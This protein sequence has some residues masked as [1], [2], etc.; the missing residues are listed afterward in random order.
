M[1][2]NADMIAELGEAKESTKTRRLKDTVAEARHE[3]TKKMSR[4]VM[5]C[6]DETVLAQL[7]YTRQRMREEFIGMSDEAL[8]WLL[9]G[10]SEMA[11][12]GFHENDAQTDVAKFR[13]FLNAPSGI[14]ESQRLIAGIESIATAMGYRA[15]YAK[16]AEPPF[17]PETPEQIAMDEKIREIMGNKL[18]RSIGEVYTARAKDDLTHQ[19]PT[20]IKGRVIVVEPEDVSSASETDEVDQ[21]PQATL[22][23]RIFREEVKDGY[24]SW[25]GAA[26]AGGINVRG[27]TSGTAPL[28]LAAVDGLCARG[29]APLNTW[30]D[31]QAQFE[32][33]A[34]ALAIAPYER[35]DYHSIAETAA[36]IRHY[37]LERVQRNNPD[38]TPMQPYDAFKYGV[39]MLINA[40][41]HSIQKNY[42]Q[43]LREALKEYADEIVSGV[44]YRPAKMKEYDAN[45]P[46]AFYQDHSKPASSAFK[47]K[48]HQTIQT[49]REQNEY[50]N[51]AHADAEKELTTKP[52]SS[53]L[54]GSSNSLN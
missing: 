19:P 35:G 40:A 29:E 36:G 39:S 4:V 42:T 45:N 5:R 33:F 13:E 46:E 31:D 43:P 53:N 3:N 24:F 27:N 14:I 54:P 48:L 6:P 49:H 11:R 20:A 1:K 28:T 18:C 15:I 12:G 44:E 51:Q 17:N 32:A 52:D 41:T 26:V 23:G 21:Q 9:G 16:W 8:L 22:D 25:V 7:E 38:N 10:S 37:W 2:N 50:E 47:T 34:G 30:L